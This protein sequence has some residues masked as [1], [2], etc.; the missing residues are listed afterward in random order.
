M[1]LR[2]DTSWL[3]ADLD[4]QTRPIHAALQSLSS[5]TSLNECEIQ[6]LLLLTQVFL[7]HLHSDHVTD[8]A[9]LYAL[10]SGRTR[11]LTV[12]GPSGAEPETGTAAL[13][14]GL[15]QAGTHRA[16]CA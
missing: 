15:Q 10:A 2:G 7:S 5:L 6:V 1:P 13:I 9:P 3:C 11:A 14:T 16:G 4:L 12:Y 8:L